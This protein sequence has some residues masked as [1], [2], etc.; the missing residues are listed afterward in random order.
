MCFLYKR[1]VL[2]AT[3]KHLSPACFFHLLPILGL[4]NPARLFGCCFRDGI[5][6][7]QRLQFP[8]FLKKNLISASWKMAA[9]LMFQ[10]F[11]RAGLVALAMPAPSVLSHHLIP[12]IS[13]TFL[14]ALAHVEI[15]P[16]RRESVWGILLLFFWLVQWKE[17]LRTSV[18][19]TS[20]SSLQ[21]GFVCLFSVFKLTKVL[22]TKTRLISPWGFT[23]HRLHRKHGYMQT[24]DTSTTVP[25]GSAVFL[26][27]PARHSLKAAILIHL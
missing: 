10:C 5:G 3:Q 24:S 21:L 9:L 23:V 1:L 26:G 6:A 2:T 13:I 12:S 4:E 15:K 27:H 8:L 18:P 19:M 22:G 25:C 17:D 20:Q 11:V 7:L 14:L 16:N